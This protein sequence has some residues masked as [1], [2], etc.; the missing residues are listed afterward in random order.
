[1]RLLKKFGIAPPPPV[2]SPQPAA[3]KDNKKVSMPSNSIPTA[4]LLGNILGTI[5]NLTLIVS[6]NQ[7]SN[8]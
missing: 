4:N 6:L 1:M 3:P 2:L 8:K 7:V 5:K